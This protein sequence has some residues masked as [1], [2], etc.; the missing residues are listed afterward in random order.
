MKK[1]ISFIKYLLFLSIIIFYQAV[2][3]GSPLWRFTPL[4]ST[5]VTVSSTST[6]TVQYQVTNLSH[7]THALKLQSKTGITQT[8]IGVGICNDPFVLTYNSSCTLS[9][10]IDGSELTQSIFG[11]PIV[12]NNG[13]A[14]Q[15]YQP[16]SS[17][18]LRITKDPNTNNA[19]ISVTG[20]PLSLIINSSVESLTVTNTSSTITATNIMSDFTGTAL[21][22]NV[23]E[24]SNTCSTL[25]PQA[26]CTLL[27]VPGNTVVPLTN[28][29]I[30][31]SNTNTVTASIQISSS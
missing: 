6:V 7:K 28:F 2:F 17:N 24:S 15:C 8:T 5:T 1:N 13:S 23:F 18:I 16:S 11:G 30:S 22:G 9:L 31:G 27:Y 10:E 4:T 21:D 12:C 14:L 25:S 20:S 29:S 3:A 26:S 19:T